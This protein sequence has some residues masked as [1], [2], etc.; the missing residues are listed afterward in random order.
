[1]VRALVEDAAA[2]QQ[3]G[4]GHG[5]ALASLTRGVDEAREGL[6]R[7]VQTFARL[8]NVPAPVPALGPVALAGGGRFG[9][10][11]DDTP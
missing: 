8:L 6:T 5:A 7:S 10:G 2:L 3:Q 4:L 9:G 1:V 11:G